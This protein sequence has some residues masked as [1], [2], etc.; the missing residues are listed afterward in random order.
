MN[1]EPEADFD[2]ELSVVVPLFPRARERL[3]LLLAAHLLN[4]RGG[5]F[6]DGFFLGFQVLKPYRAGA[7]SVLSCC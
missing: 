2:E 1:R 6:C 7:D 4:D 3:R 5:L